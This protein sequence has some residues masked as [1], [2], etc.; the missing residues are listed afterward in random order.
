M[1]PTEA[2]ALTARLRDGITPGPWRVEINRHT[3]GWVDVI[4]PAVKVG[5]PLRATDLNAHDEFVRMQ[6]ARL[7][8]AAPSLLDTIDAL[9]ARVVE[10]EGFARDLADGPAIGEYTLAWLGGL[11]RRARAILGGTK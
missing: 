4:G 2:T 1:T 5:S 11:M 3:W 7:I 6:D 10:L 9:A 8:A